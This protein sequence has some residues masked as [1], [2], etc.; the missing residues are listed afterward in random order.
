MRDI[1]KKLNVSR[2]AIHSSIFAN[3][4]LKNTWISR[5]KT[6]T[7][8]SNKK[9]LK[10]KSENRFRRIYSISKKDFENLSFEEQKL[11][12]RK[13]K[14]FRKLKTQ[15]GPRQSKFDLVFED[16]E[17][18]THCPILKIELDYSLNKRAKFNTPSFDKVIPSKGYVRGNVYIISAKA[19]FLK[20]NS[21]YEEV[22]AIRTYMKK[23][24]KSQQTSSQNGLRSPKRFLFRLKG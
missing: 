7:L 20:N 10:E 1:G 17:W 3:V 18:P 24:I 16:I 12:K 19:N 21:S 6:G 23:A 15:S 9:A 2:Q 22:C 13:S 11:H 4:S 8:S 14:M 5:P